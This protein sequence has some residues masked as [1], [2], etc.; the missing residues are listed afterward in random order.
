MNLQIR[1][2]VNGE[3]EFIDLYND[4]EINME[5]AFA[6]IQDITKKNSAFS[7][8]F[9]VPGTKNNNYIF[10]YFFDFNTVYLNWNPNKKFE[11]DLLYDG[12]ELFNGY[13][14]MNSVSVNKLEKVYSIT[15]YNG[16]GDVVANIGDK[17]LREVDLSD[18]SHPFT[19]NVYL[20]SQADWNLF[21]LTGTTNYSY[22]NG[23]TFWGLYN[24]G[25]NYTDSLSAITNNYFGTSTSSVAIVSGV[26]TITTNIELPFIIGDTIRLT[27]T[28]SQNYIQGVVQ[29]ITGQTIQFLP[30]LGLGTGTYSSWLVSRQLLQGEQIPDPTTSPIID[31]QR[32]GVPNYMTFSGT[33]VRNYY[34][35]PS[36]QVKELYTRIFNQADYLIESEFF[37]TN[38]FER[39]YL[40]LKF[41][42]ETIYTKGADRLCFNYNQQP[43][44]VS[45]H[46]IALSGS[47]VV[48]SAITCVSTAITYNNTGF[49]IPSS[50]SSDTSNYT[51]VLTLTYESP[52]VVNCPADQLDFT[53]LFGPPTA[54]TTVYS[55]TIC[56]DLQPSY[57]SIV[58]IPVTITGFNISQGFVITGNT[59]PSIYNVSF[60]L[61]SPPVIVG[62]FDYSKEFPDNEYKQ[63]DFITSVN[64]LFNFVVVQHPLKQNTLIIEPVVDYVGKGQILDWTEKIDWDSPYNLAPTTKY[65]NGTL[66]LRFR[67]DKDY[68]NQQFNI[69]SNKTFGT[70][71]KL[72]NQDYKD[73]NIVFDLTFGSPTDIGLNNNAAPQM[74]VSN[75]AAI[76]NEQK[77][78]Q[79]TQ[80]YNPFRILPRLVFRGPVIP[81][82]N[83]GIPTAA[84]SGATQTWYAENN[85]I[86][87]WQEVNRFST[88]PFAFSGF[89]QYI[90]WNSSNTTDTIQSVFPTM[91]NMYDVYYSDYI[92][93]LISPENKIFQAKI[94][95]KPWEIAAL[96][97]DEKIL[98]KN[99]YYRVNKILNIN[100]TQ[101]DLCN[102]ELIGLTRDYESH[103]VKYF[104]LI[105]CTGGTD[106]H[107]TS[108]L[109]YNMY[110]Y[111]GNYVNIFTGSTTTYTS[112]GCYEVV[113]GTP[114]PN[115]DYEQIFIG[116]GFTTSSVGVYSD[117]G[118]SAKTAFDIVQQI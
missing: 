45:L 41:L 75:M 56:N 24:I 63:I 70:F 51:G 22:Q 65:I 95:L 34:F 4:E 1:T 35:K 21:P 113:E 31:F 104:D 96:R 30:N 82:D 77:N 107:T 79:T 6:E 111:V 5:V 47:W 42:D 10:N 53:V 62:N 46:P 38:F 99:T 48:Q 54:L 76:K 97:F 9:K 39:F 90:N 52:Q 25:Y 78:G 32:E 17:F 71:Q 50:Y 55:T 117:C 15:F 36:L 66:D 89:S 26:K 73:N 91:Y 18:L 64:K 43:Q 58:G 59:L 57:L 114:N 98:I 33:P 7:K 92:E 28:P 108:D 81:N 116:S 13:I 19:Q 102:V 106:Y 69:A 23:K 11:A 67:L 85:P 68:G 8:E 61:N 110:A 40:P 88:Y 27:A 105:S 93:D 112:I 100:L 29:G 49:T 94:Y 80:Q 103:P 109:N 3:Q 118:C 83:W 60:K 115:Y 20:Q 87:Y 74:T 44:D 72:L 37:Q 12:Y 2:Y 86:S 101:P 84:S 16:V 14:R